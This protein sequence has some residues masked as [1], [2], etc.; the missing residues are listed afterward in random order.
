MVV[1]PEGRYEVRGGKLEPASK[2]DF[3]KS[4]QGT[5]VSE[6]LNTLR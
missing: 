2:R 3:A 1:S 6:F 5:N 4:L